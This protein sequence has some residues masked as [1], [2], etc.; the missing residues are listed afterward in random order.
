MSVL[1]CS[2]L[3]V[4]PDEIVLSIF[5]AIGKKNFRQRA[6]L[7]EF[8]V[9]FLYKVKSFDRLAFLVLYIRVIQDVLL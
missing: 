7:Y 5:F 8:I 3:M 2:M 1:V 4:L 6:F 9:A